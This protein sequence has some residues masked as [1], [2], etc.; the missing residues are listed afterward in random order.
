MSDM[1]AI[2]A[3]ADA[4]T[5]GPWVMTTQGGIES[6]SYA[7]PGEV[8]DS[9]GGARNQADWEFIAHARQDIP[10]LLDTVE[11][12]AVEIAA[13][14]AVIDE[15][16]EDSLNYHTKAGERLRFILTTPD[17]TEGKI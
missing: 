4:A 9:V 7:G 1:S 16:I 11:A 14:R 3:R 12:Q 2:Q 8:P 17:T 10:D 5:E 13:L 15:A 6:A